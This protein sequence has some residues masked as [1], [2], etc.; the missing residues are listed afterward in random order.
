MPNTFLLLCV[1]LLTV[2]P[3]PLFSQGKEKKIS[4]TFEYIPFMKPMGF[5]RARELSNMILRALDTQ[6]RRISG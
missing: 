1:I 2:S 4:L 3:S 6:R 5:F